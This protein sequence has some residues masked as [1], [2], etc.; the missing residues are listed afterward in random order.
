MRI[1]YIQNYTYVYNV[2]LYICETVII[3]RI[4]CKYRI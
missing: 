4:A 1:A 3:Y 2:Y